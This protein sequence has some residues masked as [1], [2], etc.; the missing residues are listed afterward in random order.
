MNQPIDLIVP[1]VDSSDPAWRKEKTKYM[2]ITEV[3]ASANSNIR[4][5][6][7]DNLHYWFRAV[8]K[9]MP[10]IHKVL[11]VTW[12]HIPTFLN[13]ECPKLEI[14][15]HTDYIPEEYLPTF[16]SN[17]I[18]M[19]Y[20]RIEKLSENFI[21]FNDD[22]FPLQPIPEEYY[23]QNDM[24]CDEAVESPI[25][26]VDIGSI[27]GWSCRM[28]A[29]NILFINRHFSK[30]EVQGKNYDKWFC[31]E[32]GELLQR[33]DGLSYWNNF[34]GF[35][36][37]HMASAM[38]KSTISKLWEIEPDTLHTASL[39]RFRGETDVS[40]YLIRYWQLC[41]GDFVPR[42]TLGRSFLVTLDNCNDVAESIK[43]QEWQMVSL[44]EE[45]TPGEFGIIRDTV[46]RAFEEILP[47]KSSF[48]I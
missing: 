32:Y 20:H 18:E 40:Q 43:R 37:P 15:N 2:S 26:P 14:V 27:S 23:F 3:D 29:N 12:G 17:T 42:K 19:N 39:N 44:N 45:C 22:F 8:E 41:E 34:C 7:W 38:K 6:S 21:L 30:R 47:D 28:K 33:N 5:Q 46:N 16:N 10:W 9:F 11:F 4:Y 31:E 36:D 35:H 1:W 24:V 48:E 25:M 13:R